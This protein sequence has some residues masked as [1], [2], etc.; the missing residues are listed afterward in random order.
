MEVYSKH[1]RL[2]CPP[3][4]ILVKGREGEVEEILLI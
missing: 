4:W 3:A 1:V 2:P